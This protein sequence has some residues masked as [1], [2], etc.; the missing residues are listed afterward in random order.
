MNIQ[1]QMKVAHSASILIS[2]AINGSLVIALLFFL[3]LGGNT[4]PPVAVVKQ[5]QPTPKEEIEI[6]KENIPEEVMDPDR[7]QET[8]IVVDN[9][10]VTDFTPETEAVQPVNDTNM[11]Q[12]TELLSDI[13]SPVQMVGL[14]S[15]R[16]AL[17]RQAALGKYG[18]GDKIS[19]PAVMKALEWLRDHQKPD[20]SWDT[21]GN[22]TTSGGNTGYTGLALL[23]F[24]AHGE[25]P[26]SAQFGPTV[27]KAIRFLV[28]NQ[29]SKG[30]FQPTGSHTSYGHAMATYALAEAYTMTQN[31]LI[32]EPLERGTRVIM[33]GMQANGGFDYD[34]KPG[35]RN[36]FSVGA[37][38]VQ[39]MKAAKI[40]N[41][42][43]PNLE[44]ALQ[45]G[46]DGALLNSQ[47]SDAGRGFGYTGPGHT[48]ILSSAGAL[49]LHLTGRGP[50]R[51]SK[52]T[53]QLLSQYTASGQAPA[54]G[55]NAVN[56]YGGTINFW[57]Y[58]VQ[59]FFHDDPGG[60]TFLAFYRPMVDALVKNQK[61]DGHWLCFSERGAT[62]GA[63]YNTTLA[64]LGLMVTYRHLPS[65]QAA[66]IQPATPSAAPVATDDSVAEFT[67]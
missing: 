34:Y 18:G 36:D 15:G 59:A 57:Y 31:P 3:Q 45:K 52:Q 17:S 37:W 39:A 2:L 40:A 44:A 19:G 12:L 43:L 53:M 33:E 64:A 50:S 61:S 30:I 25:T 24:L 48:P 51:E 32:K 13:A 58:A 9:Q 35:P 54:W 20:G 14:M 8:D 28:E 56:T 23:T 1:K 27:A 7:I 55:E 62:Q 63:V 60:R 6:P 11:N 16:T 67:F 49:C 41:V 4:P 47:E 29:D 10:I 66:N 21:D 65:T 46:M 5:I 38:N 26:S 42:A 22:T